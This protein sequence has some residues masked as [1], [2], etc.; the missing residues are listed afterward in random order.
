LRSLHAKSRVTRAVT[1][2]KPTVESAEAWIKNGKLRMKM[3]PVVQIMDGRN[4]LTFSTDD[5]QRRL[6][7][8]ALP[9]DLQNADTALLLNRVIAPPSQW[10]RKKVGTAKVLGYP[11]TIYQVTVPDTQQVL[12]IWITTKPGGPIPLKQTMSDASGS[13]T[14]EVVS[15]QINPKLSDSLFSAPAGYKKISLPPPSSKGTSPKASKGG[16]K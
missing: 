4:Q 5:P 6:A 9:K 16:K 13:I 2:Q 12:K 10:K 15:L 11:A 14:T 1:G 3:G 7:V 8:S